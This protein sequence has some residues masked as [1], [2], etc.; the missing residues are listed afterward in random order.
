MLVGESIRSYLVLLPTSHARIAVSLPLPAAAPGICSK[1]LR[2]RYKPRR[3]CAQLANKWP[4]KFS[5][6]GHSST[7]RGSPQT[8]VAIAIWRGA[9]NSFWKRGSLRSGPNLLFSRSN[10]GA[11]LQRAGRGGAASPTKIMMPSPPGLEA[12]SMSKS[13]FQLLI[14]QMLPAR[15]LPR[16]FSM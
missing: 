1:W 13:G 5:G 4:E 12:T 16:A 7:G 6:L 15:S 8:V 9:G 2:H 3:L 10:A 14:D 11:E